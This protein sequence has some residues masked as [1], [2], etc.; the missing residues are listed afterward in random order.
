MLPELPDEDPDDP[1]CQVDEPERSDGELMLP[2]GDPDRLD[3]DR[4]LEPDWPAEGLS[5]L[6]NCAVW[7]SGRGSF[8]VQSDG[9]C[10]PV[11]PDEEPDDME[12]DEEE[13]GLVVV[14]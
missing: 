4:S 14:L 10:R 8:W 9:V 7:H 1:P 11:V 5:W 6:G 12:P 2:D 3:P 13:P